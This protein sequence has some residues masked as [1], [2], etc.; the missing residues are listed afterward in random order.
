M[1]I[2]NIFLYAN[3]DSILFKIT[4]PWMIAN[5]IPLSD[6]SKKAYRAIVYSLLS[7]KVGM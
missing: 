6:I 5:D 2:N 7:L 3:D 4:H 1:V